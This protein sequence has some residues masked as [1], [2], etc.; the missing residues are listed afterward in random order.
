[1]SISKIA[2]ILFGLSAVLVIATTQAI[3]AR[4]PKDTHFAATDQ[5]TSIPIGWVLYCQAQP[6][7]CHAPQPKTEA[8]T[9]DDHRWNVL[10]RINL[11]VNHQI[12]GLSDEDHYHI[13]AKGIANWWTY[14]DDGK[15]NC[16]DYVILKKRLLVEAGLDSSALLLT[17][18][19]DHEQAGHLVLMVRTD[20]GDIILDNMTDDIVYWNETGYTFLKRQT[21]ENPNRWIS[22]DNSVRTAAVRTAQAQQPAFRQ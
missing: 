10:Q 21:A 8:L 6:A 11:L 12:A 16:N 14:P 5:Q 19:L 15:G 22:F 2:S 20:R 13:A 3:A 9:L 4:T 17:V 1:M 7:D 18:V